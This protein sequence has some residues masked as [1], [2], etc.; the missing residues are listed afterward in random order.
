VELRR[1]R[2]FA[3]TGELEEVCYLSYPPKLRRGRIHPATLTFQAFRIAV[4]GEI[5]NLKNFL[6]EICDVIAESARVVVVSYHSLEDRM[7]K[8]N[9]KALTRERGFKAL[10][11]KPVISAEEEI[12][13]NPRA[14]SAKL[15]AIAKD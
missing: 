1:V 3:T 12:E 8:E 9:F 7:V 11:K 14:R 10:T 5:E 2:P 6:K 15:R 4:N 13:K